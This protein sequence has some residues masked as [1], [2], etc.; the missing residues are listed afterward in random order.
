MC[1][2]EHVCKCVCEH[3][4]E[5]VCEGVSVHMCGCDVCQFPLGY[6]VLSGSHLNGSNT[7]FSN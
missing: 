4:C 6:H 1:V 7:T 2:C 5:C 3:V